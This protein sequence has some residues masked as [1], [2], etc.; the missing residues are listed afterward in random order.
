MCT[1]ARNDCGR[2]HRSGIEYP[3]L[4]HDASEQS[5]RFFAQPLHPVRFQRRVMN[6]GKG[7]LFFQPWFH[8]RR[9]SHAPFF[10]RIQQEFDFRD[11]LQIEQF[12]KSIDRGNPPQPGQLQPIFCKEYIVRSDALCRQSGV[13]QSGRKP[14][15]F[16]PVIL[17]FLRDHD[18]QGCGILHREGAD[19]PLES[20]RHSVTASDHRIAEVSVGVRHAAG[21]PHASGDRI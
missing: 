20:L 8:G 5:Q 4:R 6:Q 14:C 19:H 11:I 12:E 2:R 9:E 17:R 3:G 18:R 21:E 13:S 1:Q 10:R 16:R 7:H 15:H